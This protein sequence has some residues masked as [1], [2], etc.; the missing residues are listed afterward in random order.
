MVLPASECA[1]A[2]QDENQE[3]TVDELI[4]GVDRAL[5]VCI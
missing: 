1:A 4:R 3:V 5:N 2:G